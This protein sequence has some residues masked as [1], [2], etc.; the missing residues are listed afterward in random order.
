MIKFWTIESDIAN[1]DEEKLYDYLS[2]KGYRYF[3]T[4]QDHKY[5]V[6]FIDNKVVVFTETRLWQYCCSLIDS[7]NDFQSLTE[8]ERTKIKEALKACK[9]TLKKRK[10]VQFKYEDLEKCEVSASKGFI[11]TFI[12]ESN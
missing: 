12:S 2:A 7:E 1:I 4:R 8:E 11:Q 3:K 10:L 5:I 6:S 9:K